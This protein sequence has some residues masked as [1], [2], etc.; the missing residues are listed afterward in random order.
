M[1][2]LN[3]FT[4]TQSSNLDCS[5]VDGICS[6]SCQDSDLDCFVIDNN[7]FILI[8]KRSQETGRFLGEVDGSVMTYLLNMGV[9]SQVTMYDYQAMCKMSHHHHNGGR[10]LLSPIYWIVTAA[11][12]LMSELFMFFLEWGTWGCWQWESRAEAHK[13]KKQDILQPCDTEYPVFVYQNSIQETNGI[14]ECG[15]CRKMFV[16]QQ[17]PNSNLLLVVTDST[18]DCSMFPPVLQEA[19]EVKY[20]ASVKCDRM[21]SQKLRR[22]PDTCH[23]F[24]PEE[25]AQDCGGAAENLASI[26]LLLLPLGTWVLLR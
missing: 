21:R 19:T 9:F 1:P 18:C 6:L 17:I 22:R 12:W 24:H 23:A 3:T 15:G 7:G 26:T 10:H 2:S 16:I 25:N 14:M 13:L 8:S 5:Q 20:N 11:K 4:L